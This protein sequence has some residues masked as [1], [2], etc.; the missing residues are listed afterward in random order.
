MPS[1]DRKHQVDIGILDFSRAFDTVP[2]E[3]LLGKLAYYGIR[4]PVLNWVRSFLHDRKME[5]AVDEVFSL[6]AGIT[7]G[8]PQGTILGLLLF[9]I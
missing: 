7:S 9:L 4:G 1:Y 2:H 8:V 3:R 6:V 5:V